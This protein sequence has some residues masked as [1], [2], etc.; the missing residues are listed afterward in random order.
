MIKRLLIATIAL[1][2]S[3]GCNK[4]SGEITG[5]VTNIGTMPFCSGYLITINSHNSYTHNNISSRE[6]MELLGN[7]VTITYSDVTLCGYNQIN[8]I[9]YSE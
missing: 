5:I 9:E 7:R 4:T 8:S 3:Q 2:L 1:L 6:L